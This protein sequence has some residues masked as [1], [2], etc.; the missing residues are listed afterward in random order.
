MTLI[1][2]R[3]EFERNFIAEALARVGTVTAAARELGINRTDLH[4]RMKIFE[5][6][7]IRRKGTGGNAAWRELSDEC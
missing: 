2:A 7:P 3:N 5:I 4:R 6:A 1:E